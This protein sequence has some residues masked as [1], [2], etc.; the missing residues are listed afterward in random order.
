LH[1]VDRRVGLDERDQSSKRAPDERGG[2]FSM[3][4]RAAIQ[5]GLDADVEKK[6][7]PDR[8]FGER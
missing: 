1:D 6:G 2:G 3:R 5:A 8:P 7:V 4:R